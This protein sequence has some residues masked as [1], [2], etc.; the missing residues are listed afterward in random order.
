MVRMVMFV[1]HHGVGS[2]IIKLNHSKKLM[3]GQ[4]VM[5]GSSVYHCCYVVMLAVREMG[6]ETG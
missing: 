4:Y 6:V 1:G 2:V 5:W 3:N